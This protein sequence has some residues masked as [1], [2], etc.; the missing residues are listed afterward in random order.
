MPSTQPDSP[1]PPP[2]PAEL[3]FASGGFDFPQ[4]SASPPPA[5]PPRTSPRSRVDQL[6][7]FLSQ[8]Y[9]PVAADDDD[10]DAAQRRPPAPREAASRRR[11]AAR[12]ARIPRHA[13]REHD[14]TSVQR[15][16]TYCIAPREAAQR[17][18]RISTARLCPLSLTQPWLTLSSHQASAD[19]VL[20]R[21][22]ATFA[23]PTNA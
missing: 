1:S 10:D 12:P 9:Q 6:T 5:A 19:Q 18:N 21:A 22:S 4:A 13:E 3:P 8:H 16:S 23:A 17:A 2:P 14:G 15:S 20:H 7:D 11:P